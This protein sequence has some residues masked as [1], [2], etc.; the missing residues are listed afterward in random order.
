MA[1]SIDCGLWIAD[2]LIA[3]GGLQIADYGGRPSHCGRRTFPLRKADGRWRVEKFKLI[4][5]ADGGLKAIRLI[6]LSMKT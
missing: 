3:D 1:D 5:M 2:L 6:P 4:L